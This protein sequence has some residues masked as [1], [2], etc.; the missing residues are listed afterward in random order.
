M[1]TYSPKPEDADKKWYVIDADDQVL[2][3]FA[4]QIATILRGKHKPTFAPHVDMGDYVIVTNAEKIVLTG[5]KLDKKM[6]YRHSGYPG[7][8]TATPYRTL[9]E[10]NPER[11]I[12]KAVKGMLPDNSIGR[13]QAKKLFVYAGPDHP[14]AAQKPV[15]YVIEQIAQ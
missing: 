4:S 7:G 10:R 8:L 13:A 12:E 11:V 6:D 2:G 1:R 14:H 5:D 9:M 15:P 3:R